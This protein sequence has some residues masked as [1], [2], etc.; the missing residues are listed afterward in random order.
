MTTPAHDAQ[1]DAQRRFVDRA[2]AFVEAAAVDFE[3]DSERTTEEWADVITREAFYLA[4]EGADAYLRYLAALDDA[5]V[6][7]EVGEDLDRQLRL[8]LGGES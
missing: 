6:R 3:N 4:E 1:A 8:I 2:R 5:T 7:R